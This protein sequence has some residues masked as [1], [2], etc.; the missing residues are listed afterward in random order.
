[1]AGGHECAARL[2]ARAS[3]F[4]YALLYGSPVPGYA[5]P[6]DTIGPA[7]RVPRVL[8]GLMVDVEEANLPSVLRRRGHADRATITLELFGHLHQGVLDYD[9]HFR[10]LTENVADDLGLP[11]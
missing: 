3:F 10:R 11:R 6:Q 4:E 8:L 9:A 7:Q 5:A 1:L 2:G